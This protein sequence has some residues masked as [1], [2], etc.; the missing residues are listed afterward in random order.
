M[1]V[2]PGLLHPEQQ[3]I[4]PLHPCR[5]SQSESPPC[6][7]SHTRASSY[8]L[9]PHASPI[10]HPSTQDQHPGFLEMLKSMWNNFVFFSLWQQQVSK[11]LIFTVSDWAFIPS[12][13]KDACKSCRERPRLHCL[14]S[15]MPSPLLPVGET[16]KW[17]QNYKFEVQI[18]QSAAL[19]T[20]SQDCD[21][22]TNGNITG[23]TTRIYFDFSLSPKNHRSYL[24]WKLAVYRSKTSR[25]HSHMHKFAVSFAKWLRPV[26]GA[27][28]INKGY[29][30]NSITWNKPGGILNLAFFNVLH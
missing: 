13:I 15:G 2:S 28:N 7:S 3:G 10:R 5:Q 14:M 23:T 21:S 25:N 4:R 8:L 12:E 1:L 29:K 19:S 9:S 16:L 30:C 20:Q 18:P 26:S 27:K 22:Y 17:Y 6:A 11:I 24:L